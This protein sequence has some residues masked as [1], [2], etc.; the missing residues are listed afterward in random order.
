[1]A[2]P[3]FSKWERECV[4]FWKA[5]LLFYWAVMSLC[6]GTMAELQRVYDNHH[7]QLEKDGQE[8][9]E[10]GVEWLIIASYLTYVVY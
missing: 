3:S 6:P 8:L 10:V 7:S 9:E 2:R 4:L 5:D 1:M